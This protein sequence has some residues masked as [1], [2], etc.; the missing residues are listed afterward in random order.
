MLKTKNQQPFRLREGLLLISGYIMPFE[1]CFYKKSL[2]FDSVAVFAAVCTE[3]IASEVF[4]A[5]KYQ[6]GDEP[7]Q[8]IFVVGSDY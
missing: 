1:R 2:L 3:E 7:R 6:E 4:I 8:V 5:I